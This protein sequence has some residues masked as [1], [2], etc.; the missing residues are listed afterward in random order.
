M[1]RVQSEYDVEV[2]FI[3]RLRFLLLTALKRLVSTMISL[4]NSMRLA[5]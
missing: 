2:K 1:S 5:I 3:D 4:K